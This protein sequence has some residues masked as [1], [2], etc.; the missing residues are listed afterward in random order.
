MDGNKKN[1][2]HIKSSTMYWRYNLDAKQEF[3]TRENI[4][5]ILK[6]NFKN[7]LDLLHID[8]DGI[9]YW[10]L[11]AINLDIFK[12]S[13]LILEYNAILGKKRKITVP[14]KKN[15]D[16]FLSHYSGKYFGAS[17]PALNHLA[18]EKGYYFIGCN[19]A[20]NNAYFLQ[21]KYVSKIPKSDLLNNFQISDFRESRNKNG[22]LV[23]SNYREEID[24]IKG[25]PVIN[26]LTGDEEKF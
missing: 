5:N 12:P 10:I 9:D 2:D 3:I 6:K 1:I 26:I 13:I 7:E 19:S 16:R 18:E 22:Q 25:M 4:D 11:D 17:L 24:S 23:F 21:N 14:Y 8:L 20:G 15:F